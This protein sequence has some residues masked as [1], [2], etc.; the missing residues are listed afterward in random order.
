MGTHVGDVFSVA[1]P[2]C[3]ALPIVACRHLINKAINGGH[4]LNGCITLLNY[5]SDNYQQGGF[6]SLYT[7]YAIEEVLPNLTPPPPTH[8]DSNLLLLNKR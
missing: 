1:W 4:M 5:F 7:Y 2:P 6:T 8:T 3:L